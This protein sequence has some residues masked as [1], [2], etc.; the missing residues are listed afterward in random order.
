M[1]KD[2]FKATVAGWIDLRRKLPFPTTP[3]V[4]S[5]LSRRS[6]APPSC[7]SFGQAQPERM[8]AAGPNKPSCQRKHPG[9]PRTH[10]NWRH[11]WHNSSAA[12][13]SHIPAIGNAIPQGPANEP[14]WK[15]R[16]LSAHSPKWWA[17]VM[18]LQTTTAELLPRPMPT[19]ALIQ[20]RRRRL[21]HPTL[22]PPSRARWTC[23]GTSSTR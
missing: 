14:Y 18:S 19:F 22:P 5:P 11:T 4:Q 10:W 3:P 17:V 12:R 20:Q 9:C 1:T 7:P 16:R 2:E 21:G 23:R 8:R 13:H 6:A 15:F